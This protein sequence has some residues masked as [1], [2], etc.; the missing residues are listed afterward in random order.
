MR[1]LNAHTLKLELFHDPDAQNV[2]Y[3][4][5]SH[6]WGEDEVSFSDMQNPTA[7]EKKLGFAKIRSACEMTIDYG[8]SYV[9]VDTCCIDKSSS[10]ELSEAINSMF[11]WYK[12][13]AFCF[14]HLSD[15]RP[16]QTAG[17][18]VDKSALENCRWFTR[19]WTLQELIAPKDLV[20]FDQNWK[21]IGTKNDLK[22]VIQD[23]TCINHQI[24]DGSCPLSSVAIAKRMSWASNRETTRVEDEAYSLLG[25][26]DINMSMIYGEGPRAFIRLQ[27]EILRMTTDLSIFA[28]RTPNPDPL[29]GL[30]TFRGPRGEPYRGIFAESA[31]EFRSCGFIE[32]NKDQFQFRGEISLTNRGV[33]IHTAITHLDDDMFMLDLHCY[34]LASQKKPERLCIYLK[35]ELDT[36]YR[37]S[38]SLLSTRVPTIAAPAPRTIY[39]ARTVGD[40]FRGTLS[41]AMELRIRFSSDEALKGSYAVDN[42]AAVPELFWDQPQLCFSFPSFSHFLGFVRFR[43]A[44]FKYPSHLNRS[45]LLVCNLVDSAELRIGFR[46]EHEFQSIYEGGECRTAINPFTNIEDYGPLGDPFSLNAICSGKSSSATIASGDFC[47]RADLGKSNTSHFEINV[48]IEVRDFGSLDDIY[49]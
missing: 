9:W 29:Y 3:A 36:F 12:N 32:L 34:D 6:T 7:A 33:K 31:A 1:L 21:R 19:G 48:H 5:L 10:A 11:R 47:L 23:I 44:P 41:E 14:A 40:K 24:L 37:E 25:I 8:L 16:D 45:L 35:S 4:T 49:K 13:S 30:H 46:E 39:L 17:Q 28:W 20:F 2:K 26:F 38:P 42:M 27:E 43:I 22:G 18:S 15:L